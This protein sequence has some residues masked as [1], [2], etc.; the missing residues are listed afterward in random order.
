MASSPLAGTLVLIATPIGRADDLTTPARLEL[1]AVD[2]LAC[3]DT[4]RTRRLLAAVGVAAPRLRSVRRENEAASV[5]WCMRQLLAGRR[6]GMVSDAGMPGVSDPGQRLVAGVR[7]AG[8]RVVSVPGPSA[9]AEVVARIP[10]VQRGFAFE[11]FP[12]RSGGDRT[13]LLDRVA[14]SRVPTVLF[15]SPRRVE[16]TMAELAAVCGGDRRAAVGKDLTKTHER[17]VVGTLG[18]PLGEPLG[19]YVVVVDGAGDAG[20]ATVGYH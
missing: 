15:E 20:D 18:T 14:T 8:G 9:V 19:E 3:E 12:P 4:R 10:W 11:G 2:V 6:V 16:A 7:A 17:V 13:R 5:A 1:A